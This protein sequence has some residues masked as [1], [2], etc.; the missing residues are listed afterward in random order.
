MDRFSRWTN[1]SLLL[2][3]SLAATGCGAPP[4]PSG[5]PVGD[6][7]EPATIDVFER[8]EALVAGASRRLR[9]QLLAHHQ[10][11]SL[12]KARRLHVLHR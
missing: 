6:A 9:G 7:T 12:M 11:A 3:S 2:V 4:A 5:D 10:Q 8:P 1:L